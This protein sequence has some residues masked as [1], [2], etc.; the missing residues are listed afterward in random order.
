MPLECQK[1]EI[2]RIAHSHLISDITNFNYGVCAVFLGM[3]GNLIYDED[4]ANLSFLSGNTVSLSSLVNP[5]QI[6]PEFFTWAQTYSSYIVNY[7]PDDVR[8]VNVSGDWMTGGLYVPELTADG[9]YVDGAPITFR[10]VSGNTL[11]TIDAPLV[12]SLRDHLTTTQVNSATW[13]IVFALSSMILATDVTGGV[14]HK[15]Y[16]TTIQPTNMVLLSAVTD[17]TP[18]NLTIHWDGPMHE[19]M[20]SPSV[21][22]AAIPL[23][24]VVYLGTTSHARR[25]A[26]TVQ[27][28]LSAGMNAIPFSLEDYSSGI[29]I[30]K[31]GPGPTITNVSF[32]SYP[33][34]QSELK[35]GDTV[36]MT[37][38][39]DT[40]DVV[41][42]E[43][44]ALDG[45][46]A[47]TAQTYAV[48]PTGYSVTASIVIGSTNTTLRSLPVRMRA[49]NAHGTYGA[50]VD[51]SGLP[52]NNQV[53]SFSGFS[54]DYPSAQT[55]FKNDES[56]QV[57][58]TVSGQGEN[59][60]Y[61]YSS[62]GGHFDVFASSLYT[63]IKPVVL[64][65]P[66]VYNV[67]GDGGVANYRLSVHRR[68]NNTTAVFEGVVDVADTPAVLTVSEPFT[69]LRSGGSQS[70]SPQQYTITITSNQMMGAAPSML[71]TPGAGTLV[72]T[73]SWGATAKEFTNT[74]QVQD[75][76]TKGVFSWN[77]ISATNKA[78]IPTTAITG[79][80][81][82][83]LGGY[84]LRALPFTPL[85]RTT[86]I[87]TRVSDASKV[88]GSES[89]RGTVS[90]SAIPDGTVLNPDINSGENVFNR[91]TLVSL[92]ALNTVNNRGD[93]I[94]YLDRIAVVQNVSGTST[95][96]TQEI[97]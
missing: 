78:G 69:R 14:V 17:T 73:W 8:F 48:T 29:T 45:T 97:V 61:S 34:I 12:E 90:L 85:A 59:P 41:Y 16:D 64:L 95:F 39:F 10:D 31:V 51:S 23:S 88:T 13:N 72:G 22:N 54:V 63:V 37:V 49:R 62:P 94:F 53:P 77:S 83:E 75:T 74:L 35:T 26:A 86:A 33:G 84:V 56:G 4:T 15:T 87:G 70:T 65:N 11:E 43:L 50:Y 6:D 67:D 47:T 55:A 40:T 42:L 93:A 52:V 7:I 21:N 1:V 79:N 44:V 5:P 80:A 82:Y 32:G 92:S 25:F 27:I 96:T 76:D 30:R 89:F 66:G 81:T 58:L 57:S 71:E 20:G 3:S 9:L 36:N 2:K 24:S 38:T 18:A 91:F 19:W 46:Y 68:E 28:P 60:S